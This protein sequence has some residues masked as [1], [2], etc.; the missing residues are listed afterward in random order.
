MVMTPKTKVHWT[1]DP[2]EDLTLAAGAK[3]DVESSAH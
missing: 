1:I 2:R 3:L